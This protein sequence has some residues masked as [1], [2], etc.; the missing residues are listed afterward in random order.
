M[1]R[2]LI[3]YDVH[4]DTAHGRIG[5]ALWRRAVAIQKH[6]PEDFK[7]DI[8]ATKE[9]HRFNLANYALLYHLDHTSVQPPRIRNENPRITLVTSF[10]SDAGRRRDMLERC[11][12]R[13]D[14]VVLNNRDAWRSFGKRHR[15]ACI[16]NGVCAESFMPTTPIAERE[17]R[18]F[19]TGSGNPA[20]GKGL[21]IMLEAKPE[22]ERRGFICDFRP[23]N[24]IT[25]LEVLSTEML[26]KVYD[27][28]SYILCMSISDAT[29]NTTLEA[30]LM[31]CVPVTTPVGNVMEFGRDGENCV[32]VERSA[33]VLI[34]GLERAR[35]NRQ[36]LSNGIR[37]TM[38]TWTYGEPGYRAAKFYELFRQLISG[39]VPESYYACEVRP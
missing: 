10:N 37:E 20:K 18:V 22:L 17:H 38:L 9:L 34:D 30:G 28:S 27:S 11:H 16:P 33:A 2:I 8:C 36:R 35:G 14:F 39:V 5:W 23:V 21:D 29:P 31:G 32:L 12:E 13:C 3:C 19:W 26:S 4:A 1:N 6:A 7:V 15:T 25:P 24:N